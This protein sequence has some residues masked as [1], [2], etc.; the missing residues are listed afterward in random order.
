MNCISGKRKEI[1]AEGT[2]AVNAFDFRIIA[3]FVMA[4][5]VI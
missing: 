5:H 1:V 3:A 4:F 2:H